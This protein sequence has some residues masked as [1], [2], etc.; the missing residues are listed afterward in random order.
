MIN[1]KNK[2]ERFCKST[3]IVL[4][5]RTQDF[6]MFIKKTQLKNVMQCAAIA[7]GA[8]VL[9][10]GIFFIMHRTAVQENGQG[11]LETPG[12]PTVTESDL[13][14]TAAG[15]EIAVKPIVQS[16]VDSELSYTAY[17][18]REGDMIGIIA[19]KVGITQDTIISV[20]N[21]RSSRLLQIGTYLKIPSMPGI[22]YTVRTNGETADSIAQKYNVDAAKCAKV[23]HLSQTTS[24]DA[25]ATLFVPD[26]QLDWVM[27]QEIN[28]DLFIK[29]LRTRWYLSSYFG[30]RNSPFTGLR[31][32][33]NGVDMACPQGTS[34][35][36]ALDGTVTSTGY[37]ETYGNYVIISHHSG[38]KTLYGHMSVIL[39]VS[40]QHVTTSTRIGRVGS[41]GMS[42]GP[43]LHFTVFKNGKTV[44]PMNLWK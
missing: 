37:S 19:D 3:Y 31:S 5:Q 42:T 39:A 17:R 7:A 8:C 16:T 40:G 30:W 9:V 25:G 6:K 41:T 4:V 32:Y 1:V 26:A 2:V 29:P 43:H 38:Y 18:V 21:I 13:D 15:A 27:R 24:L 23:N 20:N 11:G 22:L 12:I 10:V 36:A 35:Y 33:H 44:N 14:G 28:G 34:I